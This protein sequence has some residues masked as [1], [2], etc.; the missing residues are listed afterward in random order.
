M[1]TRF[2][3]GFVTSLLYVTNSLASLTS[4][5]FQYDLSENL[6]ELNNGD[7]TRIQFEEVI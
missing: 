4:R 2:L 3:L 1:N 5:T 7:G 6:I